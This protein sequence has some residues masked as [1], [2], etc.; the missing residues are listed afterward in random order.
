MAQNIIAVP[1][2]KVVAYR[3]GVALADVK[4]QDSVI[5][6]VLR[7]QAKDF[8]VLSQSLPAGTS[9]QRGATVDVV[10]AVTRDLPGRILVN[11]HKGYEAHPIGELADKIGRSEPI[12]KV[13]TANPTSAT[14]G[15]QDKQTL[16]A[17]AKETGVDVG[18]GDEAELGQLFDT[19]MGAFVMGGG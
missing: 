3:K 15:G 18:H 11:V 5:E 13:L 12:L 1:E 4:I 16:I 19:Y 7:A 9:V 8:T 2:N 6:E 10:V 14:L 17:F